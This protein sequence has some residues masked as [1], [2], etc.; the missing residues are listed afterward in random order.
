M[1]NYIILDGYKYATVANNWGYISQKPNSV[2]YTL[3]GQLDVTYGTAE[4]VFWEGEVAA[5][6]VARDVDWGT[7]ETLRVT[8]AKKQG[9][10]YTDHY[11]TEYVVHSVIDRK[12]RSL[13]PNWDDPSNK[14]YVEVRLVKES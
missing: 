2:R 11:G 7:I 1:N 8:L 3:S 6:V 12:E 14:I 13:M 4:P 10:S 5:P 9:L